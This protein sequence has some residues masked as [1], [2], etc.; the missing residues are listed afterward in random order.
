MQV[1]GIC[2]YGFVGKALHNGFKHFGMTEFSIYDPF[3][4]PESSITDLLK[5]SMVFICVPTPMAKDGSIDISILDNVLNELSIIRYQGTVV[6]KSTVTPVHVK[7]LTSK[8]PILTI[9]ANPEFLTE[10]TA[11]ED[12]IN[13]KWVVIGGEPKDTEALAK[14]SAKLWPCAKVVEVSIHGAMM[15]K[16]MT[17]TWFAVKVSLLNEFYKLYTAMGFTDW[18]DVI[19]AFGSDTR[20]GHSHLQVPGPDGDFGWGGKCFPKDL[21]ALMSLA[22]NFGSLNNVMQA[23]WDTNSEVRTNKDWLKINWAVS[24]DFLEEPCKNA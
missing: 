4:F 6:I 16:Y 8:Y 21:N 22:R 23:A 17:N 5:C 15:A 14:L 18:N 1:F 20:V 12:F 7:A 13:T 24:K 11:N 19:K 3:L 9:I 10:R 2:G